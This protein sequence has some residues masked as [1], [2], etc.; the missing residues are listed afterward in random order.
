LDLPGFRDTSARTLIDQLVLAGIAA[1]VPLE[2]VAGS[3]FR[4]HLYGIGFGTNVESLD[5]IELLLAAVPTGV[6]CYFT[7][8]QVHGLTTQLPP[9]YHVAQ[10]TSVELGARSAHVAP[11]QAATGESSRIDK[12]RLG[13]L[14]FVRQTMPYYLTR[15]N[16]QWL[17][18]TQ[19]RYLND[20]TR[21]HVTTLEQTLLDTLHRPASCGGP[22]V[23]FEAW[24]NAR[25]QLNV[26]RLTTLLRDI[27][28]TH[29]TRRV[30]YLL[31][32]LEY[33]VD[34]PS[35]AVLHEVQQDVIQRPSDRIPLF[36]G[37]PYEG[38]DARWGLWVE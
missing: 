4:Y 30:G 31:E 20:K 38:I 33:S 36:P 21:F 1:P 37:I 17:R 11:M 29:L 16:R 19:L 5:P 15:R 2:S 14:M 32:H 35:M 12:P 7:A 22:A 26:K 27:H 18:D 6:I 34:Q 25:E 3:K 28:D 10:G 23:I 8:L 13:T 24:E 9:F